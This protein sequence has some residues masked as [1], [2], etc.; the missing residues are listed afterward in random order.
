M[1]YQ[2][3]IY[4]PPSEAQSLLIQATVG[5]PHNKCSFCMIYKRGPRY[6]V[7]PVAE[8]TADIDRAAAEGWGGVETLF[9]PAGNTIA[10]PTDQLAQVCR[11]ARKRLPNL[12]R[13]TVYG[14]SSYIVAKGPDDLARLAEAGL[15]RIHVGLESGDAE[16][17]RRVKKGCTPDDHVRAGRMVVEAGLELSLYVVLGLGGR[18]LTDQHARNTAEVLNQI[19]RADFVRLRTL[20]PKV[21]T[22]LLHQMQKGRFE[23]LGPHGVLGETK[24]LLSRLTIEAELASDHY[25]NYVNLAG[26]LPHDRDRLIGQIEAALKRPESDFRP[27]FIGTE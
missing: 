27:Q 8:I 24:N 25:T 21:N 16:V 10:M 1:R 22:L 19:G 23:L 2:G 26:P 20:V 11:H 12:K 9:L 7:R 5:C 3:P 4:R 18:E 15:S 13:I 6:A 17:L 14:S